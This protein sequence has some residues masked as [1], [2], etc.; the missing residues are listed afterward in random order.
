MGNS[1]RVSVKRSSSNKKE[2]LDLDQLMHALEQ[3]EGNF[4][5]ENELE[6]ESVVVNQRDLD[7]LWGD[8]SEL[9]L[10]WS[11]K[12]IDSS[13]EDSSSIQKQQKTLN[14]RGDERQE[15]FLRIFQQRAEMDKQQHVAV[16]S[17][18]A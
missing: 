8:A 4:F 13:K 3:R 18:A 17:M 5:E 6:I 15:K 9:S 7:E 16:S 10:D 2:E 1:L 12:E 11:S 14:I